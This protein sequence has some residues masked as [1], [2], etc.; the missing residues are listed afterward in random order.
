MAQGH[1]VRRTNYVVDTQTELE[2]GAGAITTSAVGSTAS[3][4]LGGLDQTNAA[5][6]YGDLVVDVSA[7]D[8]T[9]GDELYELILEGSTSSTFA[10]GIEEVARM[11]LGGTTGLNGGQDIASGTGRYVVSFSNERNG[12]TYRYV[13][14][15][16]VLSGTTPSITCTAFLAKRV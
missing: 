3:F 6:V 7:I 5:V 1:G 11:H 10:S 2:D 15:N 8:A 14:L 12:R 9:T 16:F 4:D 13:R